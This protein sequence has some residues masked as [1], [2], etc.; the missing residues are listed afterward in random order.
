MPQYLVCNYIPDDFDP[1]TVTEAMIEEIT[2][3]TGN[4]LLPAPGSSPAASHRTQFVIAVELWS[5]GTLGP[6]RADHKHKP[7]Y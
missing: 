7:T 4:L 5:D 1:S 2:R 6:S 3:L